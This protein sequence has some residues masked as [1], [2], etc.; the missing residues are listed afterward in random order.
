MGKSHRR[1][2]RCYVRMTS[3]EHKE[4]RW[5]AAEAG[6]T[7]SSF[8]RLSALA[9]QCS[10]VDG[11]DL[12]GGTTVLVLDRGTWHGIQRELNRWGVNLNQEAHAANTIA[13]VLST[14]T[15]NLPPDTVAFLSRQAES[16]GQQVQERGRRLDSIVTML[17]GLRETPTLR[18]DDGHA[19]P[20]VH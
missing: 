11:A 19:R 13:H 20:K 18:M 12:R 10:G 5:A 14:A 6:L 2:E 3:E 8:M 1:T 7:V 9:A 4:I 16:I 15:L 17:E